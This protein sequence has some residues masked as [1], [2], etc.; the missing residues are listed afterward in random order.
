M[1]KPL[2]LALRDAK[3]EITEAINHANSEHGIPWTLILSMIDELR[4]AIKNAADQELRYV[5][6]Q[7]AETLKHEEN[8]EET[9]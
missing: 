5:E 9:K 4:P 3:T 7:Y 6:S 2:L 1:D 8:V